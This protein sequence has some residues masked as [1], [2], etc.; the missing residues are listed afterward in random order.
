[1]RKNILL[2]MLTCSLFSICS[3]IQKVAAVRK[4]CIKTNAEEKS[5]TDE[6][7]DHST[8]PN[9]MFPPKHENQSQREPCPTP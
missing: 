6:F 3:C 7:I 9:L 8:T 1:M 4:D 5:G 2:L